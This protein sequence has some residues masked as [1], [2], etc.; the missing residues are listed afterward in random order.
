MRVGKYVL[1]KKIGEGAFAQVRHAVHEETGEE[2]AVKVFDRSVLPKTELERDVKKEIRIMQHLRHPNIVSI[3]AVLVTAKKMYLVMELVRGGELYDEIVSRRRID[4]DTSRRYFQQLVDAMVYCHRRGV[5]HRDLKPENLLLDGNGNLKVTDFGM[6][7]MKSGA[8]NLNNTLLS[9]QCGTPKYMAP[10]VVVRPPGGYCGEKLDAWE[11]GMVLFALLAGYLPFSGEN[12]NAVFHNI[13]NGAVQFPTFFTG[14]A[15]TV[16]AALLQKD[17]QR[18]ASLEDIRHYPW[19]RTNYRGDPMSELDSPS[20]KDET[21]PSLPLAE[22]QKSQGTDGPSSTKSDKQASRG[23]SKPRGGTPSKKGKSKNTV[24]KLKLKPSSPAITHTQSNKPPTSP[25]SP[26][27]NPIK[28]ASPSVV[29]GKEMPPLSASKKGSA[30]SLSPHQ[31]NRPPTSPV[32]EDSARSVR[33]ADD[34]RD[35]LRSVG[36]W[37]RMA[38]MNR[39]QLDTVDYDDNDFDADDTEARDF[40]EDSPHTYSPG[41]WMFHGKSGASSPK[42]GASPTSADGAFTHTAS[43]S[44]FPLNF[45][46][47]LRLPSLA[48]LRLHRSENQDAGG[49]A[50]SDSSFKA[51]L[52]QIRS[53]NERGNRSGEAAADSLWFSPRGDAITVSP[54]S[55]VEAAPQPQLTKRISAGVEKRDNGFGDVSEDRDS[56]DRQPASSPWRLFYRGD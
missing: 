40:L 54:T 42:F 49:S 53:K 34:E 32:A 19:F 6:S 13:L 15:K 21:P 31:S 18:R 50:S 47:T 8:Q 36:S 3:H 29:V 1:K 46:A 51:M 14:G 2:Y 26:L 35:K 48:Q 30:S 4:E 23:A 56:D 37:R 33:I 7:W 39:L 20:L 43:R 25:T 12:D 52:R 17:P 11:C 16:L 41:S 22:Q 38:K 27:S 9:T 24:Q 55:V 28:E 44:R 45:P 5:V 10:E